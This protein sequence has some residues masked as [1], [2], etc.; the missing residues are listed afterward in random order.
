MILY[1]EAVNLAWFLAGAMLAVGGLAIFKFVQESFF[2]IAV[3]LPLLLIGT[4]LFFL[5]IHEII[6]VVVRPK[7]LA[8]I[9]IFCYE[10]SL[11]QLSGNN[12]Q[13]KGQKTL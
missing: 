12:K 13:G 1:H 9:C 11:K 10:V 2:R 7:R 8:A 3:G 5:K 6:L 4:G